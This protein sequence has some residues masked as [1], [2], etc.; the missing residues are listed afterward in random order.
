MGAHWIDLVDPSRDELLGVP[1]R[2]N[3]EAL[4][5]L[6]A[7]AGDGR[8]VRP[9]LESH[10]H[11]LLGVFLRPTYV[12]EDKRFEYL[13]LD[14][15]VD[16]DTIVTVRKSGARG[17]VVPNDALEVCPSDRTVAG[18]MLH[19]LMDDTADAYLGLVD[20]LF[21]EI[22]ELEDAVVSLPGPVTRQR[23]VGLRHEILHA[24]RNASATRAAARRVLDGR[25]DLGT[26]ELFPASV[27]AAFGDT[28]TRSS[29]PLKSSTSHGI[30]SPAFATTSSRALPRPR[31]RSSRS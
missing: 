19:R 28:S 3:V 11:H 27:E 20:V 23:I 24:R 18:W 1:V 8:D 10:G 30:F 17:E 2:L 29:A 26:D 25:L 9:S 21:T 12:E 7:H 5:T 13:E 6:S 31:T 14:I 22:D 16:R 15:V 4:E